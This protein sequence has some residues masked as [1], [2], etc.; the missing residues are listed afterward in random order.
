MCKKLCIFNVN[1]PMTLGISIYLRKPVEKTGTTRCT[2]K[3]MHISIASQ[4]SLP[5]PILLF[6]LLLFISFC[7]K[8][9]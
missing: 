6:V 1:N 2:S 4:N 3:A 9:T 7:G 5:S 8:N